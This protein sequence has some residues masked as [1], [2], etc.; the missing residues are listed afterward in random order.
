MRQ[1]IDIKPF[2][3]KCFDLYPLR[4]HHAMP[5]P[6]RP[7]I[8][9][10]LAHTQ[11]AVS[12]AFSDAISGAGGSLPTWLVLLSLKTRK[13]ANQRELADAVNIREATLT[14]HLNAMESDGLITRERDPENRRIQRVVLTD[15]GEA[16]FL[17]LR[18]AAVAFNARL[19]ADI[20]EAELDTLGD[21]FAR[22]RA[23]VDDPSLA[24][25][26]AAT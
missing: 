2:E 21:L 18:D 12:R 5:R 17:A 23:N 9:V 14:H 25:D 16:T 15:A 11:K 26:G 19:C 8:G 22:L 20:T 24:V 1:T 3:I 7:P 10:Q 4:Y 13:P 6:S